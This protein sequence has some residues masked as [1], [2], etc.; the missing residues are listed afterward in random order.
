MKILNFKLLGE[1]RDGVTVNA[2]EYFDTNGPYKI[3]D[4]VTRTRRIP[5]SDGLFENVQRLK[6]YFLKITGHW[7][8]PY[9]DF[10]NEVEKTINPV[11]TE[12]KPAHLTLKSIWNKVVI[13]GG[14]ISE[15]GFLIT[16]TIE[17]CEGKKMGLSTPMLTDDDGLEYFHDCY[18]IIG[19]I[20]VG[21]SDYFNSLVLE[22]DQAKRLLPK[23][24]ETMT[25][26]ELIEMALARFSEDGG[27]VLMNKEPGE[28]E[29][30]TQK[31]EKTIT[32]EEKN[33]DIRD[34]VEEQEVES[35]S[36]TDGP[37][38]SNPVSDK[39]SPIKAKEPFGKPAATIPAD[40]SGEIPMPVEENATTSETVGDLSNL[41]H[42]ENMGIQ[43]DIEESESRSAEND[44]W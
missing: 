6:Y 8:R 38:R 1:G 32:Q 26:E 7:I 42:S 36:M 4:V 34:Y 41:E 14:R 39:L 28:K 23:E 3:P 27:I 12:P 40:I 35:E 37:K 18:D 24:A 25:P 31:K 33:Q 43:E 20:I 2:K 30:E 5:I 9:S 10:Y 13:T 15:N 17:V 44:E 19:E 29:E 11:S 21:I 22:Y 16:G